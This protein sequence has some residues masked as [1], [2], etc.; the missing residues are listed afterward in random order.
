MVS[1]QPTTGAQA[2]SVLLAPT[3][4]G[5]VID[6]LPQRLRYTSEELADNTTVPQALEAF[7]QRAALIGQTLWFD[8]DT[9]VLLGALEQ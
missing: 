8:L 9:R 1:L 7:V 5:I 3:A 2:P 6:G 4:A